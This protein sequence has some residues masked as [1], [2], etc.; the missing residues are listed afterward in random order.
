[1]VVSVLRGLCYKQLN[2]MRPGLLAPTR[3][4]VF[5]LSG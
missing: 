1:M 2:I 5:L 4:E 3:A